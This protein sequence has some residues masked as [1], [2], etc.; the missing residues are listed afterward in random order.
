MIV[1]AAGQDKR[2]LVLTRSYNDHPEL[3][4]LL[5][6]AFGANAVMSQNKES[7]E[8]LDAFLR[9]AS[10]SPETRVILSPGAWEGVEVR[11][12]GGK[13]WMTELVIPRLPIIPANVIMDRQR[14][15]NMVNANSDYI[16]RCMKRINDG[17]K[18][19]VIKKTINQSDA[20]VI[21][22]DARNTK[23]LRI[24]IQGVGRLIRGFD[25]CGTLWVG[26]P[27]FSADDKNGHAFYDLLMRW[28]P[29]TAMDQW[30]FRGMPD[31]DPIGPGGTPGGT[32]GGSLGGA[33]DEVPVVKS[34]VLSLILGES[35]RQRN[36]SNGGSSNKKVK[37][38]K[39][40]S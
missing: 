28:R 15:A 7:G 35:D 30:D 8:R 31:D 3:V 11:T 27:R 24:F 38:V 29:E 39:E 37:K 36:A 25:D 4:P 2:V 21:L 18:D 22:R 34:S 1:T 9:R 16:R 32:P 26:D 5:T 14:A 10:R 19:L 20:M 17:E 40:N 13:V 12:S 33:E 23:S 6:Q